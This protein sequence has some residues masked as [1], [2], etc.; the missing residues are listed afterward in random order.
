M[1]RSDP[2]ISAI[3]A[4]T[5]PSPSAL[6]ARGPRR[7]DAFI[8]RARSFIAARSSAVNP[9]NLSSLAVLLLADFAVSFI[10][11]LLPAGHDRNDPHARCGPVTGTSRFLTGESLRH[12]VSA[13]D[14]QRGIGGEEITPRERRTSSGS[15]QPGSESRQLLIGDSLR[16]TAS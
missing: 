15:G 14:R 7:A 10:A 8:S 5:S 9:S 13:D 16:G 12:S 11:G 3:F 4:S 6:A 1:A 2:C